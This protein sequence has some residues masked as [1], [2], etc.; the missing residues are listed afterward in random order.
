[1]VLAI[2]TQP[3]PKPSKSHQEWTKVGINTAQFSP[4]Y[5]FRNQRTTT[6]TVENSSP[7]W[8]NVSSSCSFE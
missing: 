1:M 6:N 2:G 3:K 5:N 7:K 8:A 4:I